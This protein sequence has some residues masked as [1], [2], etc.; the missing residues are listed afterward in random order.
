MR[1]GTMSGNLKNN[2]IFFEW[3]EAGGYGHGTL[4]LKENG[5]RFSG[6]WGYKESSNN[7]GNWNGHIE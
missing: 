1:E 7:G 5:K 3:Y 2:T 6:T 4:Y